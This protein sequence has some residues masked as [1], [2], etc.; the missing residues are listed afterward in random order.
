[1]APRGVNCRGRGAA[2]VAAVV[3]P[4]HVALWVSS[5]RKPLP[6]EETYERE[7]RRSQFPEY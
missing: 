1:M 4:V 7:R 3:L 6:E 2:V 5:R